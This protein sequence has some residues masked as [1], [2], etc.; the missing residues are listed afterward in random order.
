[1]DAFLRG[2]ATIAAASGCSLPRSKRRSEAQNLRFASRRRLPLSDVPARLALG[3]RA[4][5]VHDER[6]DLFQDFERLGV[7]D[8]HAGDARRVRCRP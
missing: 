8:E 3:E 5:F 1:M 4:G 6:V 2:R 7:L